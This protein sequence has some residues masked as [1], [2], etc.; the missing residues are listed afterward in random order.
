[1]RAMISMRALP[2][3]LLLLASPLC[4]DVNI[5]IYDGDPYDRIRIQNTACQPLVGTLRIDLSSSSGGVIIDTVRG[6]PGT[7]DPMPVEIEQGAIKVE[8]VEDGAQD[9][10]VLI[11]H[12]AENETGI[13]TLD[14]DDTRGWWPGP[15]IEVFGDEIAGTVATLKVL[16]GVSQGVFDTTGFSRLSDPVPVDCTQPVDTPPDNPL[17]MS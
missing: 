6:G 2:L 5:W 12:L 8:P 4:A 13:V 7:K 17:P 14:F 1:M 11:G 9:I 16:G 3:P 10:T 15:R